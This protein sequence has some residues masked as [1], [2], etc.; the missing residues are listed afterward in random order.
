MPRFLVGILYH[1]PDGWA[2]RRKG[3]DDYESST[4][5]YIEAASPAEALAWGEA[6]GAELLRRVNGDLALD[7]KALGYR[8]W[9]EDEAKTSWVHCLGFFQRVEAGELPDFSRMG[10]AAYKAW[11][12]A[13]GVR[14]PGEGP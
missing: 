6:V 7:W 8:C 11:C 9:L 1:E 4:A 14:V 3:L 12:R 10:T 5:I 13:N 2:E